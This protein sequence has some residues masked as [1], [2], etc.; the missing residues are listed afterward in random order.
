MGKIGVKS[1]MAFIIAII[2]SSFG[3]AGSDAVLQSLFTV[4]GISYSVSV[5]ILISFDLSK[6]LNKK[7]RKNIRRELHHVLRTITSD[8]IISV[9]FFIIG[10][11]LKENYTIVFT[12]FRL[13]FSMLAITVVT[14]S[15]FY[16]LYNFILIQKLKDDLSD[17]I[18]EEEN[19]S[20]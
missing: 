3:I 6:I 9:L 17:K 19:Q 10:I 18:S 13:N 16:E 4:I 14:F 2:L 20:N 15:L 5:S 1:A 7:I 11:Y 12:I 8:F